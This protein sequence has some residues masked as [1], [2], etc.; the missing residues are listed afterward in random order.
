M[1]AGGHPLQDPLF[2]LEVGYELG[3][4][5]KDASSKCGASW[6]LHFVACFQSCESS[7]TSLGSSLPPSP[8]ASC[9]LRQP[10]PQHTA[11]VQ[12]CVPI[13]CSLTLQEGLF[14]GDPY[15]FGPLCWIL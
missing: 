6:L 3:R 10:I 4:V 1:D 14:H 8:S 2:A 5:T 11:L 13:V 12:F 7:Q 15:G 9:S